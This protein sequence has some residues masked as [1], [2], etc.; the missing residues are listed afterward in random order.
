MIVRPSGLSG[1]HS[2]DA[3]S[4]LCRYD[5]FVMNEL[6]HDGDGIPR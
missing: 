4:M 3:V 2:I 6:G 5:G 1:L